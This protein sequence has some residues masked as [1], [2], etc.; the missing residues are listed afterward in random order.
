MAGW[1]AAGNC[2]AGQ[3]ENLQESFACFENFL[4]LYSAKN[5]PFLRF[6]Y[7]KQGKKSDPAFP[8]G[9]NQFS[10]PAHFE[11]SAFSR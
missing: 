2:F 1:P 5:P 4:T 11:T 9:Q 10:N 8:A 6:T 3:G 7:C